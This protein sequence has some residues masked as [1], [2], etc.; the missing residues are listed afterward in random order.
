M[1]GNLRLQLTH[2]Q[3]CGYGKSDST[4][5]KISTLHRNYLLTHRSITHGQLP[6]TPTSAGV[7]HLQPLSESY[8]LYRF[9]SFVQCKM[10]NILRPCDQY[11]FLA[12]GE[13]LDRWRQNAIKSMR[14]A[15]SV[16]SWSSKI[17]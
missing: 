3:F 11:A 4:F 7:S 2:S 15:D 9:I 6:G 16:P 12:T 10:P 13:R 5:Y 17:D 1:G 14:L 8:Y